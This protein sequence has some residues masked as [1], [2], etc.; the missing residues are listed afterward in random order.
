MA[1]PIPALRAV[2]ESFLEKL[3]QEVAGIFRVVLNEM[4]M[5]GQAGVL[6]RIED[7]LRA[8]IQTTVGQHGDLFRKMDE[9]AWVS[10]EESLISA[11]GSYPRGSASGDQL[12]RHLFSDDVAHGLDF[13]DICRQRYDAVVLNP[14]YTEV[15]GALGQYLRNSYTE[16]WTNLYSAF[17]ERALELSR[18][19]VGVVCSDSILTGYRM[20]NLRQEFIEGRK[21]VAL[22]PL[23]RLTFDGMGLPTVAFVL[24]RRPNSTPAVLGQLTA[25]GFV[26]TDVITPEAVSAKVDFVLTPELIQHGHT[27]WKDA[28]QLGK[29]Y[30][31]ITSGNR[32]FDDFRYIRMWWEVNPDTIGECWHPWQEGGEYQPFFSSTPFVMRWD[33]ATDGYEIRVFGI[34]RV[35]TDAQTA[36]SSRYWWRPGIVGPTMNTT[37]AGFN[38]RVLPCGTDNFHEVHRDFPEAD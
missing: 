27:A 4:E 5:A 24:D 23:D 37:G 31:L 10:T 18:G 30:A 2:T 3:R 7:K 34:Q 14:P 17:I 20:R 9:E 11:L 16:N 28:S 35:G 13:I 36:Q 26:P 33:K 8:A 22:A 21:L 29:K 25:S 19:R 6:L 1:A 15:G 12:R 38:A 32:T